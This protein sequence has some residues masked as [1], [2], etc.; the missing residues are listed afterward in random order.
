MVYGK[1]NQFDA[2]RIVDLLGAYEGFSKS[3]R[4]A[5]GSMDTDGSAPAG[6]RAPAGNGGALGWPSTSTVPPAGGGGGADFGGFPG[7]QLPF[8]GPALVPGFALL[9]EALLAGPSGLASLPLPGGGPT[10]GGPSTA[11][12]GLKFMFSPEGQFFREFLMDEA[13]KG[14]DALSREQAAGAAAAL[15]LAGARLPVLLPGASVGSVPLSPE[16]TDEDR[17]VVSNMATIFGFLSG[18]RGGGAAAGSGGF[19][20]LP[21]FDPRLAAD[22]LPY[23]PAVA[24]EVLPDL[25]QRLTSRVVA[26]TMRELYG[27][28]AEGTQQQQ[29]RPWVDDGTM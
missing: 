28:P 26:R 20:G 1:N 29:Q 16:V 25:A 27:K 10:Q 19:A 15:G 5:R 6:A 12:D 7:W 2:E 18:G 9:S 11:R 4:S 13:V 22:M 17:Q 24:T 3:S 21:S 23:L 14:V 8:P